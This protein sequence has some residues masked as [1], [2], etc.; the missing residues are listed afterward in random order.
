[1]N[2]LDHRPPQTTLGR[3]GDGFYIPYLLNNISHRYYFLPCRVSAVKFNMYL[4]LGCGDG[5]EFAKT[6]KMIN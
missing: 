5:A 4:F 2:V 6:L 1:M 3:D